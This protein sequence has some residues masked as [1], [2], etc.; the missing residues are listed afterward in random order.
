MQYAQTNNIGMWTGQRWLAYTEARDA[1]TLTNVA[2]APGPRQLQFTVMVPDGAEAQT[3]MLPAVYGGGQLLSTNV[4]SVL[5]TVT[6]QTINGRAYGMFSMAPGTATVVATY[7]VPTSS[8]SVGDLSVTEGTGGTNSAVF[9]VSL[10]PAATSTVAVNYQ[11]VDGT[12]AAPDDFTAVSGTLTFAPGQTSQTVPVALVTDS[13]DEP[14]ESFSLLLSSAAN[15]SISD[16]T[17]IAT[18]VNDDATVPVM[19][20]SD[21]SLLEG[22][23][24]ATTAVF[25]VTLSSAPSTTVTAT[26][27]TAGESATAG[28]D[29]VNGSGTVTFPVGSTSQTVSVT[30]LGD[31]VVEPN[32]VFTV[33]LSNPSGAVLGDALGLGTIVND[34][35]TAGSGFVHTTVADFGSGTRSGAFVGQQGDG[36]LRLAGAFTEEYAAPL[37]AQ[38]TAGAWSGGSI[39]PTVTG[40]ALSLGGISGG[41]YVR[42]TNP[43]LVTSLEAR[44]QFGA[45]AFQHL[46]WA[47]LD[48]AT[49]QYA[50]FSTGNG[51]TNLFART[52]TSSGEQTTDLGPLPT[53]ARTFRIDRVSLGGVNAE[54][55]YYLD[56]TL[57]A[58]HATVEMPTS[59][60]VYQS[61]SAAA[62]ALTVDAIDVAPTYAN[63]GTFESAII[64]AGS[65]LNWTQATWT[66]QQP[67]GTTLTLQ[68]RTSTDG[69]TFTDWSAPLT[70]SGQAI[71]SAAGRYLQYRVNLTTANPGVSPTLESLT[72]SA[73]AA[74]LPVLSI[75]DVS[76]V[77]GNS[78]FTMASFVVNLSQASV[79]TVTVNWNT[80]SGTA[81]TGADFVSGSGTVT[82]PAGNT[83]QVANVSVV[84]DMVPE[85]NETFSVSLSNPLGAALG[86][87]VGLGTIVNDDALAESAFVHT[88]V[89]DFGSGTRSGAFVGQQGDG[90]LRLAGAF[91]EEYAAPLGAQWT[92]GAWS[93]GS[94][95]PTVTG[96]ALSLGGIS[97]GAYVRSTNPLLVTSLEARAQF[98]AAAFQHL[99][100]ASLDFATSQYAIFSTGNGTTN[101]FARTN[102]SSGE[103]TTDL[104]PLPTTAR[105]F[106]I[107][108]VSLGGVNAEFRYYL[109]GTLVA[110]HAT[111]E[112]PTSLFVYQSVSAAAPALTVDAIDVAPTYANAG[113]FESAIIDAGST[114]NWTQATWTAQQPSG[115][116]LTLQTRTSTDGLTF[117]DWSAPLTLSGQAISS[118][119]GRYL[120]YR[121]NLTTA[122]PGVSPTLESLTLSAGLIPLPTLTIADL[123]V[124]EGNVGTTE[125]VFDV[126]LSEASA[127]IITASWT[128][129]A[130][131]ATAGLDVQIGSGTVVFPA[132]STSQAISV[133][134]VAD[135]VPE[136][137]ETFT[138]T[139]SGSV[140][141]TI[142]AGSATGTIV[143]DDVLVPQLS[144]SDA[145]LNEGDAGIVTATFTV[146]LSPGSA[147]PVTVNWM[148]SDMT[149]TSPSDYMAA[150]GSLA[151]P[152]G[153]TS[154]TISVVVVGDSSVE[155][156]ETFAVLLSTPVNAVIADATGVGTIRNDDMVIPGVG[157]TT[158]IEFLTGTR[159]G[160]LVTQVGT[161][162]VRLTGTLAEEYDAAALGPQWTAGLWAG[163]AFTPTVSGGVLSLGAAGG[164]F[165]RSSTT[166]PVTTL[167]ARAQFGAAAFQHV[168]WA[169]LDFATTQ[170]AIFS[171][172]NTTTNVFAR[173]NTSSGEQTT[174]LGPIPA[175][176]R[177]LRIERVDT[178]PFT[179]EFRYYVDNALVAVHATVEMPASL[180]VYQSVAAPAPALTVD[181]LAV[182]PT[183]VPSGS[184]VSAVLDAGASVTWTSATWT[185]QTPAGTALAVRTRTSTDGATFSAWSAPMSGS[186]STITS[187]AGRY[188]QYGLDLTTADPA[189]SPVL[190]DIA[191][192]LIPQVS[193]DDV[194]VDEGDT[195][196]TA[197]AFTVR[198][199]VP[200]NQAVTVNW[201]T[202]GGMAT[203]G[204]DFS[205]GAGTITFAAGEATRILVIPVIG[206]TVP[207]STETFTLTLSSPANATLG[208]ATAVATIVND[209]VDLQQGTAADLLTGTRT[210]TVVTQTGNGEVRLSGTFAEE[211]DTAA[212]GP[213]WTAGLWAGG[214]F[215]PTVSG[216][217]LSLGAAGGAYVRSSTTLPVTT[218]Q[219]RVQ[220]GAAAFQHVGWASLDFA[221]TQY[222]LFS[223]GDTTTNVFAR[224][225]T[226]SGEQT[227]DLG[228]IPA[229]VRDFRIERVTTGPFTADFRYFVDGTLVAVHATVEMPASLYVYQSVAAPAPALT[230]DALVVYPTYVPSGSYVSGVLDAGVTVTWTSATWTGQTPAGTT[231]A[232]R[233]RTSTDG[234]TFSAW[235]APMT[236][237]GSTI[238]SPAG[239][240]I[241]YGLDLTT[242]DPTLSPV[243]EDLVINFVIP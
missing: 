179:A 173:T 18:I 138:V 139:L 215:T 184:Y 105:T 194:T 29:F 198:L 129:T 216:G 146:T 208:D 91:T 60:F 33:T 205:G 142:A 171:T 4:N 136:P 158:S 35:V 106:R 148:T 79:S 104:G 224:T 113:T 217:V 107:D 17:G 178:G 96:G 61:V 11:T 90:E 120:Q 199:S 111:V 66:A 65:T 207:E 94:I 186:G 87:A 64:D 101:L 166:L 68:T 12:A 149:A 42:S 7:G 137:D 211:Y 59:L 53:T 228:P 24:G 75:G 56:G 23:A 143:N 156:D 130:G 108:R 202:T 126:S 15:A 31:T 110:T 57:V 88:T 112:M 99:G 124:A 89:A 157:Q 51:T 114:L 49:S 54:F 5:T 43:L 134:L 102:T 203:Q 38:W 73:G 162:E 214:A 50:I 181:A 115:T 97:G 195:G 93:G 133:T 92:A 70:L 151:F 159:T 121:V 30:V 52:N 16:D 48:F 193:V 238:T 187:P 122:N 83:S 152:T 223:T 119:A 58:T 174:D 210:G 161:G 183:Y 13:I 32:E 192:G 74:A 19:N 172:G 9:V 221:T 153:S 232:V 155:P 123:S 189:V 237:G 62:P 145:S 55:R 196:T 197:A 147:T 212:L 165:V 81:T 103:Q 154:Q 206:D 37:G 117:T 67:S 233:T 240:Y 226:S 118:A 231:L 45:A 27:Q 8:L 177:D 182:Y 95:T 185:G 40:G 47:S 227:T 213:Q 85:S 131:S 109:D 72:L 77:E 140:N 239:R 1:T 63:A 190:E 6:T 241:Q 164:A 44:A 125:A 229:T 170:Y 46:G 76:V 22:S 163:G 39:T 41:A 204:A 25:T 200:T 141:A 243:L 188:I 20:I 132:G 86:D 21:T 219:A 82:F 180:Y 230:V 242:A 69:L 160:T 14:N 71:S 150:S 218:L 169:S 100:W 236:V 36:E 34:D 26:W 128:T 28:T 191:L 168:G 127:N 84:G 135:T 176:A 220:F 10:T 235:S 222:A 116:T 225:N 2:W 3:V 234:V 175:T 201:S 78:G 80:A 98:G 209:D 144:V 167:Q